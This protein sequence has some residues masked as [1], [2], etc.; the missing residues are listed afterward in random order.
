MVLLLFQF[1]SK[2][3]I[4]EAYLGRPT[5]ARLTGTGCGRT[6]TP[7]SSQITVCYTVAE[8]QPASIS[9]TC[10]LVLACFNLQAFCCRSKLL[11]VNPKQQGSHSPPTSFSS[12][13]TLPQEPHS[14]SLAAFSL[15]SGLL[16]YRVHFPSLSH[17]VHTSH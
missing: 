12:S 15:Y 1:E 4:N 11:Q 17:V 13:Y 9:F 7:C 10:S 8:I 16:P 6:L 2:Q 5:Y 3:Q 14:S